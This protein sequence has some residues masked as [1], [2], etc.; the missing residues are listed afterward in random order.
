MGSKK[1]DPYCQHL[2]KISPSDINKG[3]PP[4]F[5]INPIIDW[6]YEQVWTFILDFNIPYCKLYD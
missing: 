1:S 3:Y 6:S 5:R 4:F 2:E